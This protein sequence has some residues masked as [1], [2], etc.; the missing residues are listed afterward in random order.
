MPSRHVR[1][2]QPSKLTQNTQWIQ[3]TSETKWVYLNEAYVY[4]W[5][6]QMQCKQSVLVTRKQHFWIKLGLLMG[7]TIHTQVDNSI[8][9]DRLLMNNKY[10]VII[11][12][13][14]HQTSLLILWS[15]VANCKDKLC[16]AE[17]LF[18]QANNCHVNFN[19]RLS[20]SHT[21]GFMAT[22]IFSQHHLTLLD[23][24]TPCLYQTTAAYVCGDAQHQKVFAW[25]VLER[26]YCEQA[27]K[28]KS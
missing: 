3:R 19:L 17:I 15:D 13:F 22:V 24:N 26:F 9:L 12:Q 4:V 2:G 14:L 5:C 28:C 23:I 27:L 20:R 10:A 8:R 1:L 7:R 16:K 18:M 25:V 21:E 6:R 11:I